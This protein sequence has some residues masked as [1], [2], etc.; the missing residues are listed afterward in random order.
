[1]C[2]FSQ[3]MHTSS[4]AVYSFLSN[5]EKLGPCGTAC[6]TVNGAECR[7]QT[8][9]CRDVHGV[10]EAVFFLPRNCR[11]YMDALYSQIAR[12]RTH[13]LLAATIGQRGCTGHSGRPPWPATS[14]SLQDPRIH[15]RHAY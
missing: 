9:S 12:V 7:P 3:L 15:T 8:S 1:M 5:K 13:A 11:R 6:L 4:D 10:D 2:P 14:Y